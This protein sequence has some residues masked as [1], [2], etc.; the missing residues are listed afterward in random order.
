MEEWKRSA[1]LPEFKE[2]EI[3]SFKKL[4]E[5]DADQLKIWQNRLKIAIEEVEYWTKK[6]EQSSGIQL[7]MIMHGKT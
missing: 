7:R 5:Y 1:L 6:S 3:K 2:E 4:A